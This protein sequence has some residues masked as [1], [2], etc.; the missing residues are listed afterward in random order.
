VLAQPRTLRVRVVD[1]L[2]RQPLAGVLVA[3]L[4][5]TGTPGRAVLSSVE[6]FAS[7]EATG[8]GPW[9]VAVRRIGYAPYVSAPVSPAADAGPLQVLVPARRI[10][11][12]AV[13][14]AARHSCDVRAPSPAAEA[15]PVWDDV[16]KALEASALTRDYRLV[17]TSGVAFE[18]LLTLDGRL[19]KVD[20]FARAQSGERPFPAL[21]PGRL[22]LGYA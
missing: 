18:R 17:T 16:R 6:G 20:T 19:V 22:E 3:T 4:D 7:P 2:F 9:R 5:A 10:L 1:S 12:P 8:T 13:R 14:V 11:L 15:S 21:D